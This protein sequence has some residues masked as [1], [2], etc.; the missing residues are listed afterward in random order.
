ML[1]SRHIHVVFV[2]AATSMVIFLGPTWTKA[3]CLVMLCTSKEFTLTLKI[4]SDTRQAHNLLIEIFLKEG[5]NLGFPL[6]DFTD[7]SIYSPWKANNEAT[8][9]STDDYHLWC[10]ILGTVGGN[11]SWPATDVSSAGRWEIFSEV[12]Q[13][14]QSCFSTIGITCQDQT[15]SISPVLEGYGQ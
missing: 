9:T 6:Q 15:T 3:H 13:Y 14:V 1:Q 5:S 7:N 4:S 12:L 11:I 10:I 8:L 2:V